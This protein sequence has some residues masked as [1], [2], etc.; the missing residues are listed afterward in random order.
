V[1][2]INLLVLAN[3]R[4]TA[5]LWRVCCNREASPAQPSFVGGSPHLRSSETEGESG[6]GRFFSRAAMLNDVF[7]ATVPAFQDSIP[8]VFRKRDVL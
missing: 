2:P 3:H 6:R 7:V 4:W 8:K 1:S 5:L